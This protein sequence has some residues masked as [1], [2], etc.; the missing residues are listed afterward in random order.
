M[1]ASVANESAAS[2]ALVFGLNTPG[3]SVPATGALFGPNF[4]ASSKAAD[5]VPGCPPF[6][7]PAI[8]LS[9]NGVGPSISRNS[10]SRSWSAGV[11]TL[12]APFSTASTKR[13]AAPASTALP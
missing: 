8:C 5:R 2:S 3:Q 6:T 9:A 4:R 10:K 1:I 12:I 11:V 7:W 13:L